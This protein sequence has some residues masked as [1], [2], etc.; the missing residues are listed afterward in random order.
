MQDMERAGTL[1][2]CPAGPSGR[3]LPGDASCCP[4]RVPHPAT[5]TEHI[6]GCATCM[7]EALASTRR[8]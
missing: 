8:R 7:Q 3:Q 4:L 6:V 1:P 2:R 5:G